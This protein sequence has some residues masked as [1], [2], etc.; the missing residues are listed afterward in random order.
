M[1]FPS[2]TIPDENSRR[3]IPILVLTLLDDLVGTENFNRLLAQFPVTLP[4]YSE[5]PYF[6]L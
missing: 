4:R 3:H 5:A 6:V 1:L 2:V